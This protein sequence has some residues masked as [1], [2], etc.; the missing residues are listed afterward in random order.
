MRYGK[1][2]NQGSGCIMLRVNGIVND[3]VE[4]V[5]C[6]FWLY[7]NLKLWAIH[8][9]GCKS[10]CFLKFKIIYLWRI[11]GSTMHKISTWRAMW[12]YVMVMWECWVDKGSNSKCIM[13]VEC[14]CVYNWVS[15]KLEKLGYLRLVE[16]ICNL[17]L[18]FI[19]K[20]S[21]PYGV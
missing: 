17:G 15:K 18:R 6:W 21:S 11:F 12:I 3:G 16:D 2:G 10:V 9:N 8:E 19:W 5:M 13:T 14:V 1:W 20:S 4:L 7:F